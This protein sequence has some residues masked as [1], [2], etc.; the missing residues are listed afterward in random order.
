[1]NEA[2]GPEDD[3]CGL[4]FRYYKFK[5]WTGRSTDAPMPPNRYLPSSRDRSEDELMRYHLRYLL[6]LHSREGSQDAS[7]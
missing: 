7:S 2:K 1:M 6:S 4:P 3:T 5:N